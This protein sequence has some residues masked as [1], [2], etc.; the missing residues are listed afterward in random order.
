MRLRLILSFVLIILVTLLSVAYFVRQ[1][2]QQQVNAFIYRGGIYGAEGFVKGL[3]DYYLENGSWEGVEAFF[4][5]PGSGGGQGWGGGRGRG[6]GSGSE[7]QLYDADGILVY[8]PHNSNNSG[9]LGEDDYQ[10]T[11]PLLVDGI[12]RGYLYAPSSQQFSHLL[13]EARRKLQTASSPVWTVK[14]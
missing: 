11:V 4:Q 6:A 1:E 13:T 14:S 5:P 10:L 9:I 12:T 2:T 8:A 7:L 3:E